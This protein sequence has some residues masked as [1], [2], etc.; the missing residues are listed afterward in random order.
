[1]SIPRILLVDHPSRST[2]SLA[3]SL[4]REGFEVSLTDEA[5]LAVRLLREDDVQVV[6]G[7]IHLGG[8]S[9]L[10][11]ALRL[12]EGPPVI[13]F[14]DFASVSVALDSLRSSAFDTLSRPVSDEQVL[15]TVRRALEHKSLRAENRRLR[16]M[17]GECFELG[18][19]KSRDARMGSIFETLA[20]VADSR[21]TVLIQGESGTGKT[22]LARALHER[23]A[24]STGP[25]VVVN[26][27]AL[28]GSLLES[29]LFGHT[30]G[31]FTGAVKDRQGKFE[32]ADGGTI[33]LDEIGTASHELQVKLLRVIEEGKFERVGESHTRTADVR[34][35]AATNANL[36]QEVEQGHFRADLYYRIHV[37]AIEVPPLRDRPGDVSLLAQRFLA[38]YARTHGRPVQSLEPAALGQLLAHPW[39]GNVRQLENTIERA[40]LLASGPT[41]ASSD[42]WPGGAL[43]A[44]AAPAPGVPRLEELPL[45]P[46]KDVLGV[47]ERWMIERALEAHAG[48]RQLTAR[49]LG[50]NRTTLFN[51]MRKYNLLSTPAVRDGRADRPGDAGAA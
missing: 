44:E 45:G 10:A 25:F 34:I 27:G 9:L 26:C 23:S 49:T 31:A 37:V 19:L 24:R 32:A 12:P 20:A 1:M 47:A 46:L 42:L 14:D 33:L 21:A 3:E 41:L 43:T 6:L 39:P 5:E 36:L 2:R 16:G 28:P 4:E 30:R 35:I 22:V 7:E 8:D 15:L 50:V 11:E 48:N 51:K 18:P 38:T 40:V 29:E 17:V 13:L